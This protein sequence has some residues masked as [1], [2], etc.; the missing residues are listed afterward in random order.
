M[1]RQIPG[2]IGVVA[3]VGY[4]LPALA[5]HSFAAEFDSESPVELTGTVT[6]VEWLNPHVWFY[7][8][9]ANDEGEV[10]SWG[11]EM[12]S[13]NRL[14]R[15]GWNQNSLRPGQV[16]TVMASR[17]RDGSFKAA[18]DSVRLATGERLF[19]AQDAAQ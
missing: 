2:I 9:V 18:V 5:H 15:S 19:G 17:A 8:D 16:V 7:V 14:A 10:D 13:P 6:Q 12:G 1:T 11:L 3:A 4:A